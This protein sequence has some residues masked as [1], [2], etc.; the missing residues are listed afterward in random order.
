MRLIKKEKF[1][2]L[3]PDYI[4]VQVDSTVADHKVDLLSKIK[5]ETRPSSSN[6]QINK[7]IV[8]PITL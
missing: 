6:K 7:V 3:Y 4:K 8:Y 5:E 1:F 2:L